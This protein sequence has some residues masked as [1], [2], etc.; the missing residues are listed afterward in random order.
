VVRE[1]ARR[2]ALSVTERPVKSEEEA[3]AVISGLRK[4]DTDGI[5]SLRFLT[6]NIPGFMLELAMRGVLPTMFH[7]PYFVERGGLASYSANPHELGKQAARL[8][9]KI[10]KGAKPAELP[11]EQSTKFELVINVKAAK[12]LA[13]TI[14][15]PVLL[16]A[17]RLI[18]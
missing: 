15:P 6:S 11:V 7:I 4:G 12:M 13:L 16:R 5:F 18:D 8:V 9:D 2:L 10:L 17:D 1:A 3:R 14:P